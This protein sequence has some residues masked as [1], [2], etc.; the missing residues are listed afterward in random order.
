[1]HLICD[2][3]RF[4]AKAFAIRYSPNIADNDLVH[5]LIARFRMPKIRIAATSYM[6]LCPPGRAAISEIARLICYPVSRARLAVLLVS[7][8]L[9]PPMG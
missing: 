3:V 9:V 2:G 8:L 5:D 6:R 1:M 7:R 4:L